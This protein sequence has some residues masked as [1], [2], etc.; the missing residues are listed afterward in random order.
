MTPVY[1]DAHV[2]VDRQQQIGKYDEEI[3]IGSERRDSWEKSK[4]W[5]TRVEDKIAVGYWMLLS[6]LLYSMSKSVRSHTGKGLVCSDTRL[7]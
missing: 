2:L 4:L 3:E 5:F 1:M 6:K 7:Q